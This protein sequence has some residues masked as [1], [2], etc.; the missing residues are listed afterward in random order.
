MRNKSMG[1]I[2]STL[3]K[4]RGMTQ[5]EL[6]A[7]M[8]V[9]DKAVSKWERNISSPDIDTISRLA[10][11]LDTTVDELLKTRKKALLRANN[12]NEL[13]NITLI[14]I[15]I[16]MGICVVVTTMLENLHPNTA[17]IMIGIGL[18]SISIYLLKNKDNR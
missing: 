12:I 5:S 18:A 16:A 10:D 8:H 2:I 4:E 1:E 13:I 17:I 14:A 7:K 15:G 11:V 9:T 6:A 3:R